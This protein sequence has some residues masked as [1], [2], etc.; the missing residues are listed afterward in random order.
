MKWLL[1]YG[2]SWIIF[3]ILHSGLASSQ[4]KKRIFL[5]IPF[6]YYR[7]FY[8]AVSTVALIPVVMFYLIYPSKL[9]FSPTPFIQVLGVSIIVLSFYLW[10]KS[11][12][13]YSISEFA[14]TDRL[15]EGYKL[16]PRLR[17]G[18][19]NKL[20]RHPLYS[21]SYLFLVGLFV[22]LPSDINLLTSAL[23]FIYFPIGIYFEERKLIAFFGEEYRKYKS[24]TPV[25]F[26]G[27]TSFI[28]KK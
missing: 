13:N 2:F 25:L 28:K 15:K 27:L 5:F 14:G 26:P 24:N 11:F 12:N 20:V 7:L 6:T 1:C 19:L 4:V 8:N 9:L 22:L 18:G 16:Q 17:K 3:F 21:V 23:I 10:K